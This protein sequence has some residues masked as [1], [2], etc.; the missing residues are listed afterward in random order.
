MA[1]RPTHYRKNKPGRF[2]EWPESGLSP[3]ELSQLVTYTGHSKH[4][5]YLSPA[6]PGAFQ[7]DDYKCDYYP[8]EQWSQ[9]LAALR[10]A[11]CSRCVAAFRGRFPSRVWVRINGVLHEAR[12]NGHDSPNYHGFPID[13][14]RHFPIPTSR[15]NDVPNV[16]IPPY[17]L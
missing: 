14:P 16:Q 11:V 6:G 5:D 1:R 15:L 10:Q 7:A 9:L 12:Q 17:R 8:P 2:S 3:E 4:K 13:D